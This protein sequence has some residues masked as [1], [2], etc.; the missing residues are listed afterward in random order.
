MEQTLTDSLN[1]TIVFKYDESNDSVLVKNS[2]VSGEFM[3]VTK[4]TSESVIDLDVI[5]IPDFLEYDI[6]SDEL[7]RTELK[8]FWDEHKVNK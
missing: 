7:T 1:N 8:S 6:W 5:M 2:G 4:N 3:L